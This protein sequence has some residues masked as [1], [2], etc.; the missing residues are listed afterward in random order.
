MNIFRRCR[1]L[2][3]HISFIKIIL[4]HS[5]LTIGNEEQEETVIGVIF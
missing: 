5:I 3:A 2:W 4:D 1:L